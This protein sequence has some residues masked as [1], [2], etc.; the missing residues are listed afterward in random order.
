MIKIHIYPQTLG[1]IFVIFAVSAVLFT[2]FLLLSNRAH[3]ADDGEYIFFRV[4]TELNVPNAKNTSNKVTVRWY[5]D[6][7]ST[8]GEVTDNTASESTDAL[9]GIIKVA[10]NSKEM[11]DSS[12][13]IGASETLRASV[14]LDGWVTRSWTAASFPGAST[15]VEFTQRASM[16]YT[17]VING[18]A[19][20]L[21]TALTLDGTTASATYSGTVASQ[22]YSGG[23]RYIAGTTSAGTVTGGADG[24][25]N[26]TSS[27][28]TISSTASQSVDFGTTDDSSL[29]ESGLNFGHKISVT[30]AG[31][32]ASSA[33]SGT[34]VIAGVVT[35]GDSLATG[36][37]KGTGSNVG[38]WYC[39]VPLAHTATT[40]NFRHD[41]LTPDPATATYADRSSGAD[42]QTTAT[43]STSK[44][45]TGGGGG[46]SIVVTPTP[47]PTPTVSITPTPTPGVTPTV[48][49]T[50]TPLIGP[51]K[52]Y[53]K[54][55]DPKVY[56]LGADD[57]LTWVRTLEDFN[58]AG[59]NW[60]DVQVI[61]GPEFAQLKISPASVV[62]A[63][64]FRKAND[65]KVYVQGSDG[66]L[67]WVRTLEEFN[68][69]GYNWADVQTISGE[70]FGKMMIGGQIKV[71]QGI[72]FLRVRGGPSVSNAILG[73]VSPGQVLQFYEWNNGWYKIN[74][75]WV[76]GAYAQEF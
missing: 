41:D 39:P 60:T 2:A 45:S 31:G 24:Y 13:T 52:L 25:V 22:S 46:T 55:A 59:Y 66:A 65:T 28:L 5:C 30:Y 40:A 1:R 57:M 54:V 38:K 19:D 14:S 70:E 11:T 29:D 58:A 23:K 8:F 21:G 10:S 49:P 37:T 62:S 42:A 69:A 36:C 32:Q 50:P 73:Q 71:V 18:I 3:A 74:S 48:T 9:D 72:S 16:D 61:S 44:K 26:R 63:T 4:D 34:N 27:A 53:R 20:E 76:F 68:T 7:A 47:T 15:S 51:V 35:A 67:T 43:I 6:G 64:L 33:V 12:C 56:V 75:G 17:I